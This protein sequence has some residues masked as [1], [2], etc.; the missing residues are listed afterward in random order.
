MWHGKIRV[1]GIPVQAWCR[2]R[3]CRRKLSRRCVPDSGCNSSGYPEHSE[4]AV[5]AA[6]SAHCPSL[7]CVTGFPIPTH[8]RIT[9][10]WPFVVAPMQSHEPWYV[11]QA[12]AALRHLTELR[13]ADC[14]ELVGAVYARKPGVKWIAPVAGPI[15]FLGWMFLFGRV[16]DA[17]EGTRWDILAWLTQSGVLGSV[18]ALMLG[19]GVAITLA[20]VISVLIPRAVMRREL[21]RHLYSPACF[22]C[23]HSL[24]GLR[25][26]NGRIRC[27]ECGRQSPVRLMHGGLDSVRAI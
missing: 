18:G 11:T 6:P 3:I 10:R 2:T 20:L 24:R 14:S 19:Y 7:S 23:D 8:Y 1:P 15:A 16:T 25:R 5:T 27:P 13:S 9:V 22:W 21:L 17:L 26:I 4:T 12:V